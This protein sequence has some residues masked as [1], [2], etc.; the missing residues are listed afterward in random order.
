MIDPRAVIDPGA[1]LASDVTI[2]PYTI[3]GPGVEI[4]AGTRIGPHSVIQGPTRIGRDNQIFQFTSIGD[5]PQDKKYQGEP[6][7]LHIGDGNTIR[8]YCTINRGTV[9]GGGITRIGDDNWIMAYAHIAHDCQ[10]GSH[11]IFANAASLAGHVNVG[12]WAI[13]GG[14]TLVHQF[15]SLG[16][17]CFTAFGSVIGQDVPPY[18]LVSGHMARPHGLNT[19]GLRRR[20]FSPETLQQLRRAYKIIYRSGFTLEQAIARLREMTEECPEVGLFVDALSKATRGII[21]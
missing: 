10:I 7:E 15:C 13:L 16:V 14:F 8:E 12:D 17:H 21:R 11:A 4:G 3:V 9:Q 20:G 6:T 5:S 2:G 18:V 19:E 1:S